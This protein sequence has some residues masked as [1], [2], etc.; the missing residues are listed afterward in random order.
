MGADDEG[1]LPHRCTLG[2]AS[3]AYVST[4]CLSRWK[5]TFPPGESCGPPCDT[6][7]WA[8]RAFAFCHRLPHLPTKVDPGESRPGV[9]PIPSGSCQ[10]S[11]R[12]SPQNNQISIR[13]ETNHKQ[14]KQTRH[15]NDDD[16]DDDFNNNDD[17]DDNSSS[18]NNNNNNITTTT[19]T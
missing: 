10:C 16:D 17:D 3:S 4:E 6:F 2:I 7:Q 12:P 15:N 19:Y 18:S 1:C 13:K 14:L 5:T 9:V 8:A 11:T